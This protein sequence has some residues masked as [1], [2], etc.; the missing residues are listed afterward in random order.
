MNIWE[1]TQAAL[2]ILSV[3]IAANQ[4]IV[5]SGNLPDLFLVYQ[6]VTSVPEQAADNNETL[7]SWR[8]QVSTYRR[9]GLSN[10]PD[11]NSA[12][13]AAGFSAGPVRAMEL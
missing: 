3:P 12:M 7:R 6:L 9:V 8:M 10:L 5:A 2:S 13:K 1:R 11:V 4:M